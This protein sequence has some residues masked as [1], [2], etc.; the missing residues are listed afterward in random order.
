MDRSDKRKIVKERP[1]KH[2]TQVY[3]LYAVSL[4][5]MVIIGTVLQMRSVRVGLAITE[6]LLIL[7]PAIFFLYQKKLPILESLQLRPISIG[8]SLQSIAIG[9]TSWG[10]AAG[11]IVLTIPILGSP[12]SVPELVPQSSWDLLWVL[13]IAALLPGLCEEILFRGVLQG[14][15]SRKGQWTGVVITAFLFAVFH[16]NP[17]NLLPAFFLGVVFGVLVVRTGSLIPAILAHIAANATAFTVAYIFQDQIDSDV[18]P[19]IV[20][21][22]IVFCAISPYFWLQTR[23]VDSGLPM[24]ASVPAGGKR[25]GKW[26]IWLVSGTIGAIILSIVIAAFLLVEISMMPDDS[27]APEIQS[28]DQLVIFKKGNMIELDLET[29][30]IISSHQNGEIIIQEIVG[31]GQDSIRV[32][33]GN[34][35]RTLSREEILGKMVYTIPA[36][37][38]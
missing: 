20:G 23:E 12:P 22:V 14:I 19:L 6:L 7:A 29:G 33:D 21:L 13:L 11:I 27:L 34:T 16:L 38:S 30:D 26:L 31:I 37:E 2:T 35:E 4:L 5:L 15:L 10:I 9:I 3:L 24:L 18:Y 25:I 17:W 36:S 32:R 8:I 28:G 1:G